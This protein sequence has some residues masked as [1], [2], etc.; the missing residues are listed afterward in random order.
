MSYWNAW[1]WQKVQDISGPYGNSYTTVTLRRQQVMETIVNITHLVKET[2]SQLGEANWQ[3]AT[4][5]CTRKNNFHRSTLDRFNAVALVDSQSRMPDRTRIFGD[6]TDDCLVEKQS[7]SRWHCCSFHCSRT[8]SL[9]RPGGVM[10]SLLSVRLSVC[11]S[12]YFVSRITHE[13]VYECPPN[14]L[15]WLSIDKNWSCRTN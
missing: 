13:C 3:V 1:I 10:R 14:T 2:P 15:G 4:H 5:Q 6:R 8:D 7:V 9:L 12:D 11:L